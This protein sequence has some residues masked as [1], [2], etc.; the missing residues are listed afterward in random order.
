[1]K[2]FIVLQEQYSEEDFGKIAANH[3][4]FHGVFESF[5]KAKAYIDTQ[6]TTKFYAQFGNADCN[7]HII[8]TFLN[9]GKINDNW[10]FE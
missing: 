4:T 10:V 6:K 8:E 2:L 3:S 9:E 7:F 5:E 1:M